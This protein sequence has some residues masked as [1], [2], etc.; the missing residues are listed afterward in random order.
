[1]PYIFESYYA[2]ARNLAEKWHSGACP[3][4]LRKRIEDVQIC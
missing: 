3:D 2:W 1:M 4:I